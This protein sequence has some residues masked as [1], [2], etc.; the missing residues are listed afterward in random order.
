[1]SIDNLSLA[2]ACWNCRHHVVF[3]PKYRRKA[4]FG[5]KRLEIG[6]IL[7]RL[8]E[9]KGIEIHEAEVCPDRVHMPISI[10]PKFSVS[11]VLGYLKGKPSLT[12]YRKWGN[13]K[14]E[15]RNRE[16]WC[17]GYCVDTVGKNASKIAECTSEISRR[18]TRL[19]CS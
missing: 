8:C 3:A 10:P 18:R 9:W 15:C 1:M 4:F 17:R 2:H 7:R 16:F 13:A 19:P 11:G 14:S 12:V 5:L 6:Q